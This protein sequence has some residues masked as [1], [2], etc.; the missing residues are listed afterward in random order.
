MKR[1]ATM[2]STKTTEADFARFQQHVDFWQRELGLIDWKVYVFHKRPESGAY[3]TTYTSFTS[4]A[5]SIHLAPSWPDR[6]VDDANLKEC[7]LHEVMHI[8]T[9][10]LDEEA[11]A[12]YTQEADIAAAEHALVI[13]LTNYITTLHDRID[14]ATTDTAK[15]P[16]Q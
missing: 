14:T 10:G 16:N 12:R 6:P 4:H 13:R 9:S 1:R 15:P 8:A 3:A 5:A 11:R 2:T 7:A